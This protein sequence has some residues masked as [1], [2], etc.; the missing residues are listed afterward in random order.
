M[1]VLRVEAG[2]QNLKPEWEN[3]W[4]QWSDNIKKSGRS[5]DFEKRIKI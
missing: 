5:K 1:A 2:I 3:K 4:L